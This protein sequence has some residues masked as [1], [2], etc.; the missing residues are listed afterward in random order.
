MNTLYSQVNIECP[1]PIP[2]CTRS[3]IPAGLLY[4]RVSVYVA[5]PP[6]V[7]SSCLTAPRSLDTKAELDS[8]VDVARHLDNLGELRRFLRRALKVLDREDLEARFVDLPISIQVRNT[9]ES[10]LTS[11][12]A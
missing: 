11:L 9:V 4:T 12:R 3:G 1:P 6:S 7:T 5:N 10:G 8:D 2:L